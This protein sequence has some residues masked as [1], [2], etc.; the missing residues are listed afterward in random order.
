MPERLSLFVY[1]TLK[2]GERNHDRF[3]GGF[4]SIEEGTVRGRLYDLPFGFPALVVP[5]EDVHAVGTADYPAD[6]KLSSG[7][8]IERRRE[9]AG[10][11]TVYGE[12]MTFEDPEERLPR[13]DGL[14]GFRPG[15][16]GF[17]ARVLVPV[18][19]S[20]GWET[21]LAWAYSVGEG[22]GVRLPGGFWPA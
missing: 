2:R 8:R 16:G 21:V 10:W 22:S 6:A 7:A 18:T 11:D 9:L 15:E 17:Y 12:L 1:G 14:E 19:L 3:C 20:G 4:A 5:R 13:V